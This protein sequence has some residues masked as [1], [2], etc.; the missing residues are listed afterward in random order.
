[1]VAVVV[2]GTVSDV[3]VVATVGSWVVG[4][5]AETLLHPA[6]AKPAPITATAP[7]TRCKIM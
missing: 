5:P 1:V 4:E 7:R 3:V 6:S 2:G